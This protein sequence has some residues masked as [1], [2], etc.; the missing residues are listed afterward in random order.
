MA[1]V[2]GNA[3]TLP[4][5]DRACGQCKPPGRVLLAHGARRDLEVADDHRAVLPASVGLVVLLLS[6]KSRKAQEAGPRG[7]CRPLHR[8]AGGLDDRAPFGDLDRNVVAQLLGGAA[9]WL[10]VERL[11][12]LLPEWAL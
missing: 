2:A 10:H 6:R 5:R 4:V 1:V 8:D 12:L 9:D 3:Q 11:E 7:C